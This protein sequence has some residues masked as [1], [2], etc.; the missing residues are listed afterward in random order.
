MLSIGSYTLDSNLLL[1]PMAGVTDYPF[2]RLC[3]Q[4]GAALATS[5]M[6]S[7]D[8]S[9]W[10]SKK[11]RTRIP[12]QQEAAPRSVQIAGSEPQQ[13]A[14]AAHASVQQGAHIVD[15]NM[16]CPA[17]KVCNK[18][19]GSAL[20][21][22]EVLVR[23][24]LQAVV[25]AV[26]VPVTLKFRTGWSVSNRNAV[27]VAQIAE[28][29][30]IQAIAIHGRTRADAYRGYAEYETIRQVK[31]NVGIPV[32]ANGDIQTPLDAAFIL[33]YTHTDGL[34]L[35]RAAWGQPWIF[36]Q[37]GEFFKTGELPAQP[38]VYTRS[39]VVLAHIRA[40]HDFYG[41]E[42]GVRVARKH[43]GWYLDRMTSDP[44]YKQRIFS[45]T[46]SNN[47]L[48]A[49]NDALGIIALTQY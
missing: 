22:D 38:D 25:T 14:E 11:S 28:D 24:I 33:D 13:M 45:T 49:V 23:D 12:Q 40:I 21:R 9:L 10:G 6:L 48:A 27:T 32:I 46:C 8:V 26:N 41:E 47:Q 31:M 3:R 29:V 35:G 15:I 42:T 34:M 5:E 18:A 4:Y 37:L 1:A 30:G 20:L 39:Q 7:A 36:W 44:S 19:A 2:R 17:K 43:I 16:G